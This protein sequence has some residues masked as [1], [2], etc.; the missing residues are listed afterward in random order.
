[1][2]NSVSSKL[3]PLPESDAALPSLTPEQLPPGC[4]IE[5]FSPHLTIYG[6]IPLVAELGWKIEVYD[7]TRKS[8]SSHFHKRQTQLIMVLEGLGSI[9]YGIHEV[10]LPPGQSIAVPPQS[11]HK[12]APSKSV[13]L[14]VIDT[15][16]FPFPED[17]YYENPPPQ[18][19][20][21]LPFVAPPLKDKAILDKQTTL[22]EALKMQPEISERYYLAKIQEQGYEVYLLAS[23]PAGDK[24]S[25]AILDVLDA[26]PHFHKIGNE[27][28]IVL[29]GELDIT[30]DGVR[31]RLIAGQSV[32]IPPGIVHHLKSSNQTPVRLLCI[33]FP[34]FDPKDFYPSQK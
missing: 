14:L 29:N 30:L 24:W 33:N 34:A 10:T 2:T 22:I 26:Q 18:E 8:V 13:R 3:A 6:L 7:D 17:I 21:P 4:E 19:S 27:H 11:F 23:D 1:M 16:G 5:Y 32:H 12:V 31:H 15:P 20:L 25:I 9:S 28:F